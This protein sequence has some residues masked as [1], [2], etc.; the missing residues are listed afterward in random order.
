MFR[1]EN[2][3]YFYLLGVVVLATLLFLYG[4]YIRKRKIREIGDEQLVARLFIDVAPWRG[5]V[6]FILSQLAF[7]CLVIALAR[8]QWGSKIVTRDRYGIE[9]VIAVDISNSMMAQDVRPNRLEK[10]KLLLSNMIDGMNDDKVGLIIY[11]GEAFVQMPTTSDK[12]SAKMFLNQMKPQMIEMQGTDIAAAIRLSIECFSKEEDVSR[13]IFVIT[14][15]EDNEGGAVESAK[16]ASEAGARVYVLGVGNPSGAPVPEPGKANTYMVDE[17]G[18]TV[19]SKLNE[20]MCRA[21]AK[22]GNGAYIYVD[23]SSSAQAKLNEQLDNLSKSKLESE[24]YSE[25]D[26][27][28]QSFLL[29]G[30]ILLLIDILLIERR[31]HTNFM[32]NLFKR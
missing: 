9:A 11:A 8:P 4:G 12:V 29:A 3:Q 2:P 27:Q 1:F 21:I 25:Y 5:L 15:G 18:N 30:L 28:Y 20:D 10:A 19:V 31:S 14:D 6:K 24:T 32:S 17:E 16:A 22:A 23:N 7:I 13:A 26:E